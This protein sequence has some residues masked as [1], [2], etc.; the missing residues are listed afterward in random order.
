M[1]AQGRS[2][3]WVC[4]AANWEQRAGSQEAGPQWGVWAFR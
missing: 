4:E 2:P 1:G 3:S